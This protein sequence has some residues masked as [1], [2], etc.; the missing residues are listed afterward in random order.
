MAGSES[1]HSLEFS[2]EKEPIE[3]D[4]SVS[5][6]NDADSEVTQEPKMDEN[7]GETTFSYE[8]LKAK[9]SDPV[10][11]IDHKQ[12][13]AYL[14]DAEFETVLGMTKEAFYQQPK[15]KQ[16]MQKRKVDLF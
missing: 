7:C 10:S 13:E 15:W 9:S 2:S 1:E 14:S 11:R 4:G 8:R 5:E 12:R 3:G 16:D 6:S